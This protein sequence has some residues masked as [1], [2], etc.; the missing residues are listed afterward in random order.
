MTFPTHIL[1][2]AIIG[3]VAVNYSI[4]LVSSAVIDVDH[5]QSYAKHKVLFRPKKLWHALTDQKD[6]W[7]DQRGIL[8]NIAF[9]AVASMVLIFLFPKIGILISVGWFGHIL[10][11]A[12]D[13]SDYY[14]LYPNKSI[15]LRGPIKYGTWQ[16]AVFFVF[17]LFVYVFI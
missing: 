14:P 17:L 9:F 11:D 7:G 1:L 5:L 15:N 13:N 10:L 6:E 4:G 12:L 16:E 3:K 8:H 2:G